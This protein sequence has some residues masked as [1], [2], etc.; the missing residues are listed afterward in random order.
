VTTLK[1]LTLHNHQLAEDHKFT[2]LL[3]G[4]NMPKQ[5]YA[6]YLANQY[7]QYQS[8]EWY[9]KDILQTLPGLARADKIGKDLLELNQPVKIFDVTIN[10]CKHIAALHSHGLLAHIYTKHM[11]DLYGGQM[12]KTKV[13]GTGLMYQFE[14]RKELISSLR[15][16]LDIG[17]AA[18]ANK[19]FELTLDLFDRIADEYNL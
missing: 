12:I 7:L 19:C 15:E 13:M 14:N 11:G 3:L 6:T 4:G 18:E 1:D 16:K 5:V 10:Y 2:K 8:L 17:M 9:S